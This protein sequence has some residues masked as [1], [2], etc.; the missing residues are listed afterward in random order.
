M[1]KRHIYLKTW[2]E[3]SAEKNMI[4]LSGPRQVG[5]TTLAKNISDNFTNHLYLNWDIADHRSRFIENPTFFEAIER[6]DAS[7]PL[8]VL[9]EIH[10]YKNWKNYLKGIYDQFHKDFLFLVSGSGRLDLYQK[11]GDS[12]AGRYFLFYL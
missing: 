2:Q 9:D 7:L 1:Q 6:K 10:K 11:G 3:L 5:K 4:F 8:V 12:L